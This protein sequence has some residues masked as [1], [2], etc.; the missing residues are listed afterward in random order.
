MT[1]IIFRVGFFSSFFLPT[2]IANKKKNTTKT[3]PVINSRKQESAFY[4]Q[5]EIRYLSKYICPQNNYSYTSFSCINRY[6]SAL[7]CLSF[8]AHEPALA[9]GGKYLKMLPKQWAGWVCNFCLWLPS[10]HYERG[11]KHLFKVN[12]IK[13]SSKTWIPGCTPCLGSLTWAALG[14]WFPRQGRAPWGA[15]GDPG[16]FR[17]LE[18][19]HLRSL[20]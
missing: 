9:V 17:A 3:Q 11:G 2:K 20:P 10:L 15:Q 19:E 8:V 6:S 12:Q 7:L 1:N 5:S 14:F 18:W 4:Q 16:G 13:L